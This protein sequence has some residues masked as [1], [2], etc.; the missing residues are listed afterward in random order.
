MAAHLSSH[1]VNALL[2][3]RLIPVF[4]HPELLACIEAVQAAYQAGVRV[5]EFVNRGEKAYEVFVGLKMYV[6]KHLPDLALGV[7]TV[8]D[9]ATADKFIWAGADF[10]VSPIV[11]PPLGELCRQAR[12]PWIPGVFSPTECYL[13]V[14]EGA[15]FVKLFPAD[16][17]GPEFLK[18]LKGPMPE[19]KA[20]VS[21]GIQ[22]TEK[23][24]RQW[25]D[26]GAVAVSM[27]TALFAGTDPQQLMTTCL[28]WLQNSTISSGISSPVA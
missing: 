19:L 17:L 28:S 21:G 9:S 6:Q 3:T 15:D 24:I 20:I 25:M 18:T 14:Q 2:S 5:F 1:T 11:H 7:G 13:A 23:G 22:P 8:F 27:G 10:L 16:A 12:I 26:A 4:Y